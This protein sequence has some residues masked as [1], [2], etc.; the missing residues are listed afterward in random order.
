MASTA[1]GAATTGTAAGAAGCTGDAPGA[2]GQPHAR[3]NAAHFIQEDAGPELAKRVLSWQ[4]A[5]R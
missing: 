5:L 2:A 4:Q 1:T 3:I